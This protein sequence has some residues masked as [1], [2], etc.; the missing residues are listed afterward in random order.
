MTVEELLA[1]QEIYELS[2]TYMR[3]LDRLDAALRQSVFHDDATVDYG[4]SRV[5]GVISQISRNAHSK[6][7]SPTTI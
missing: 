6:R 2:C 7:I 4:F 5:Q 1:K 3:S